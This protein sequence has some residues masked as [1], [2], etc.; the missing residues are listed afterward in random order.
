M[1]HSTDRL[2]RVIDPRRT[3][4]GFSL[5]EVLISMLIFAVIT[6]GVVP[7]IVSSLQASV[8]SKLDTG[9]KNLS[10]QR[11]EYVR[12]L[13]FRLQY[14]AADPTPRDVLDIY[15]PRTT[16]PTSGSVEAPGYVTSQARR[17]GEPPTGPF[18]RTRWDI[19]FNGG[20]YTQWVALQFLNPTT[21]APLPPQAG[22]NAF[23]SVD[24]PVSFLAGVTVTTEWRAGALDKRYTVYSEVTDSAPL[25]QQ[26]ATEA[27]VAGLTVFTN[28]ETSQ[29]RTDVFL[30]AGVVSADTARGSAAEAAA[31]AR[32]ASSFWVGGRQEGAGSVTSAPPTVAAAAQTDSSAR[33]LSIDSQPV[34]VFGRTDTTAVTASL[35]DQLPVVAS[36]GTPYRARVLGSHD[37][38]LLPG[39]TRSDAASLFLTSSQD[40]VRLAQNGN[41]MQV[42]GSAYST[43]T[44]GATRS[45]VAGV[46]ARTDVV[47]LMPTVF[48][49][50]GLVQV[51]LISA[52]LT[53]TAAATGATAVPAYEAEVRFSTVVSLLD[54][55]PVQKYTS[56]QPLRSTQGSDPLQSVSLTPGSGGFPV[57]K[58]PTR[59]HYLGEYV[60][61]M[62]SQTSSSLASL[63]VV[64]PT[65]DR[66]ESRSGPMVTFGTVP[67]READPA[68]TV[69]INL[70]TMSC[71]A[72]DRR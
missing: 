49:P 72:E 7:L 48:A 45:A 52:G 57:W 46:S 18:Y 65:G 56:W 29:G 21:R 14:D 60:A 15:Y 23:S 10:Q 58:T 1:S 67:L 44:S 3:D 70:G 27:R 5:V 41:L 34:A 6:A 64:D 13:P 47:Q 28:I 24:L 37:L 32:G 71:L 53:C 31:A 39:V 62:S 61:A 33:T 69:N 38:R 63:A 68:S 59:I 19:S 25:Q 42:E 50:Q 22:Y 20:D 11:F 55:V 36:A 43:T 9:A 8:V 51:R 26:T 66:I 4:D 54:A 40:V 30:E 2:R 17:T 35:T 16:A 12:N